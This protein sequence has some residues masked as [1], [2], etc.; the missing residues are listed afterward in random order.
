[1]TRASVSI[2]NPMAT[3]GN[4]EFGLHVFK[5]R[6]SGQRGDRYT[7]GAWEGTQQR[8]I[9]HDA[10]IDDA[11][12]ALRDEMEKAGRSLRRATPRELQRSGSD[13]NT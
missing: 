6:A 3:N 13:A 7:I 9:C 1:M 10:C 11:L 5:R 2:A 8:A 4:A 12:A